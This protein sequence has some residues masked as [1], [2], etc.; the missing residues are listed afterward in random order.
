MRTVCKA[1][2][3]IAIAASTTPLA[4]QPSNYSAKE[5]RRLAYDYAKCVVARH[6]GPASEAVLSDVDNK[7]LMAR[8][9]SLVEGECLVR[10][11][12]AAAKMSFPGDLYRYALA[13]ALVSRELKSAPV[14]DFSNVP[15]LQRRALPEAPAPLRAN[16]SKAERRKYDEEMKDFTEAEAFRSLGALGECVV[17]L[18]APGAKGL[19]LTSPETPAETSSFDALRPALG[20]CLPE[21]TTLTLGRLVLR[22][23]IAVNYYRL[24]HA[25]G[26]A[27]A[28]STA[29]GH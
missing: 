28:R 3:L 26:A 13:D 5:T 6:A 11:T 22:G 23:T 21:G 16:A 24:A 4:A 27:K 1:V 9:W 18:N 17:R 20:Q 10:Q 2:G 19:L 14:P 12:H 29:E 15:P 7:T 25:A 8:Y